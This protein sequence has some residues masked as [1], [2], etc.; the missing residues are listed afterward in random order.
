ML[1]F[2]IVAWRLEIDD[3]DNL[4]AQQTA[5]ETVWRPFLLPM[6]QKK[7]PMIQRKVKRGSAFCASAASQRA[8]SAQWCA[9]STSLRL[10]CL[11]RA[12]WFEHAVRRFVWT[13]HIEFPAKAPLRH[14]ESSND[15]SVCAEKHI[16]PLGTS[17][18]LK[19]SEICVFSTWY[20]KSFPQIGETSHCRCWD[21]RLGNGYC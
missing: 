16:L 2:S 1:I 11:R 7:V 3:N 10:I 17:Q 14:G 12:S 15:Y 9:S 6:I 21:W 20:I 5:F 19:L 4:I 13:D 18:T 8:H